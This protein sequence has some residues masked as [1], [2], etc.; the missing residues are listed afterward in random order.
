[1]N[2]L[3]LLILRGREEYADFAYFGMF[4]HTDSHTKEEID[5][6][7]VCRR[8]AYVFDITWCPRRDSNMRHT[9]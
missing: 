8:R 2:I 3:L 7:K 6:N 4:S 5:R 9:D 1:L